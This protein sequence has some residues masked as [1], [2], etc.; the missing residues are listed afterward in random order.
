MPPNRHM[1]ISFNMF[2]VAEVIHIDP[3][4]FSPPIYMTTTETGCYACNR[5]FKPQKL[6]A[7]HRNSTM[8]SSGT[9]VR[10]AGGESFRKQHLCMLQTAL[11]VESVPFPPRGLLLSQIIHREENFMKSQITRFSDRSSLGISN[12]LLLGLIFT[13]ILSGGFRPRLKRQ[14][15]ART[16]QSLHLRCRIPRLYRLSR[17]SQTTPTTSRLRIHRIQINRNSP[18]REMRFCLCRARTV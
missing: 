1:P 7:P 17:I 6:S 3:S 9:Q 11:C 10:A 16:S 18:R 2:W 8:R 5:R 13:N 4:I 15:S 14:T 12:L